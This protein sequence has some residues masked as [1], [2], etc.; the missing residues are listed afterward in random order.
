MTL[1]NTGELMAWRRRKVKHRSEK[2]RAKK[3]VDTCHT[4]QSRTQTHIRT[5]YIHTH[6]THT[7]TRCRLLLTAPRRSH[8]LMMVLQ[9]PHLST[10]TNQNKNKKRKKGNEGRRKSSPAKW[11]VKG[12]FVCRS[13]AKKGCEF[14]EEIECCKASKRNKNK[15][16]GSK[17]AQKTRQKKERQA[18][19]RTERHGGPQQPT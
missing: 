13:L 15:E 3:M 12:T 11:T 14:Q 8:S 1:I 7:Y 18:R 10:H 16:T 17:T 9:H 19:S 2:E 5:H 4:T 6:Y